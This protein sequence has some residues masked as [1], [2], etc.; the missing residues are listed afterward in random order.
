MCENTTRGSQ[1]QS[2][3]QGGYAIFNTLIE[4]HPEKPIEMEIMHWALQPRGK[5]TDP[6][7]DIVCCIANFQLKEE[8]LH[9]ARNRNCILYHAAEIKLYR[10]P[11]HIRLQHRKDLC[12]LLEHLRATNISYR[13]KLPFCLSDTGWSQPTTEPVEVETH[14]GYFCFTTCLLFQPKHPW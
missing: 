13:L 11:S 6:P 4:R 12:P 9:K 3:D 5:D 14:P 8:I 1:T 2:I 7:R 10:D